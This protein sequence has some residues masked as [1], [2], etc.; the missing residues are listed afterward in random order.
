MVEHLL[1]MIDCQEDSIDMVQVKRFQCPFCSF[2]ITTRNENELM[3]HAMEHE[4]DRHPNAS[5]DE[6]DVRG[7]VRTVEVEAPE[8]MY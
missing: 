5:I 7:M 2:N 1:S 6:D 4:A 8:Q 3:K